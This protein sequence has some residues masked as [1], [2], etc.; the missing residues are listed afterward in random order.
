MI[1]DE[2]LEYAN[3]YENINATTEKTNATT[4]CEGVVSCSGC[5]FLVIISDYFGNPVGYRCTKSDS[6]CS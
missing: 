6:I 2:L 5:I 1:P 4:Y 3:A